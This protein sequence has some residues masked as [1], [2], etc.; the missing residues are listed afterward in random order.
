[1]SR[2]HEDYDSSRKKFAK[3]K[4][5]RFERP[6]FRLPIGGERFL[7]PTELRSISDPDPLSVTEDRSLF[8]EVASEYVVGDKYKLY[9]DSNSTQEEY[10]DAQ[11]DKASNLVSRVDQIS[12]KREI[13]VSLALKG[14]FLNVSVVSDDGNSNKSVDIMKHDFARSGVDLTFSTNGDESP[15][16]TIHSC[17]KIVFGGEDR[18]SGDCQGLLT[19]VNAEAQTAV[20]LGTDEIT[21][22]DDISMMCANKNQEF[23][24]AQDD[25]QQKSD[26]SLPNDTFMMSETTDDNLQSFDSAPLIKSKGNSSCDEQDDLESENQVLSKVKTHST[27]SSIPL[28]TYSTLEKKSK[29]D[30]SIDFSTQNDNQTREVSSA[31]PSVPLIKSKSDSLVLL[32]AGRSK[33]KCDHGIIPRKESSAYPDVFS[34]KFNKGEEDDW[35]YQ[36]NR[37]NLPYCSSNE[38]FNEKTFP[39]EYII[40]KTESE[41]TEQTY[42][43]D[44]HYNEEAMERPMTSA[45]DAVK[46]MHQALKPI[47]D[48]INDIRTKMIGMNIQ[49]RSSSRQRFG[50]RV[51]SNIPSEESNFSADS[52]RINQWLLTDPQEFSSSLTNSDGSTRRGYDYSVDDFGIVKHNN[53]LREKLVIFPDMNEYDFNYLHHSTMDEISLTRSSI[54]TEPEDVFSK[55]LRGLRKKREV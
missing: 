18:Q 5:K 35:E 41:I 3:K 15:F 38:W 1:M 49:P 50:R 2:P 33:Q 4:R 30:V 10:F 46:S 34:L 26:I 55:S 13:K 29:P 43:P 44:T 6:R 25:L 48:Q 51:I 12:L 54:V 28:D 7:T 19:R 40:E 37:L 22:T 16:V 11:D 47:S 23:E 39:Q 14:P 45:A 27:I 32:N 17:D 31:V 8:S 42:N 24:V 53:R 9:E 52:V 21:D 20:V 36:G